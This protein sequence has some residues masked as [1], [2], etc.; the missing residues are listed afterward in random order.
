MRRAAKAA[1]AI[2]ELITMLI[3]FRTQS[4]ASMTTTLA[5]VSSRQS[6]PVLR[7]LGDFIEKTS[8]AYRTRPD[9]AQCPR[10]DD[11]Q[12]PWTDDN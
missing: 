8:G 11:A 10:T 9:D 6:T 4:L 1:E 3:G 12:C 2:A 7:L 5:S